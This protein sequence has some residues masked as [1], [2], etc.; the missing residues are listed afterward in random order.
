[1]RQN[2]AEL[3]AVA[4]LAAELGLR[5]ISIFPVIRRDEIPVRFPELER[6]SVHTPE[7]RDELNRLVESV[8][9][10]QPEIA[11]AICNPQFTDPDVCLGETPTPC[12]GDLAAGAAIY[13][14]EQNPWE[15]AHIL[16]NG[17]V[18][19]CEVH[20]RLTLGSLA[21][22]SLAEIWHGEPYRRF[23]ERYRAGGQA[24]CRGCPWKTAYMP[25]PLRGE[26]LAARGRSAQLVHGWHEPD[27]E[28][29]LWASQQA[30]AVVHPAADA[31]ALHVH[32]IL[33]PGPAGTA[34]RLSIRCNGATIGE[35]RNEGT[36][37]LTFGEDLP[38]CDASAPWEIEF[39]TDHVYAASGD[40]RDL[41]FA[42][43]AATA[44][45]RIDKSRLRRQ[46]AALR[47]LMG[48]IATI[49]RLGR[50]M[51]ERFSRGRAE[52]SLLLP[53]APGLSVIV[54]ERDNPTELAQC[55]NGL[56]AATR[57]WQ[58]TLEAIIVVNG[59]DP[60]RY[61]HLRAAHPWIQW[62]FHPRPLG[63]CGAVAA[64]VRRA[65]YDWVY[66]LNSDAVLEPTA[67]AEV[68]R[69][70]APLTFSVASQIYL[71]DQTRYR[72][73]TNWTRILVEDG[74]VNIH[75]LIPRS[76][77]VVEHFYAGGGASL[78]QTRLLRR[79]LRPRLY[80][81]FYWEDVEWGW[82]ARKLGYRSLFCAGS[83]AHHTQRAT[84]SRYYP[85]EQVE[86]V[87]HRNRLLFQLRNLTATGSM[88]AA[89][90]AI[91]SGPR[92]T[93]EYFVHPR[94]LGAVVRGR[95]WNHLAPVPDSE[96]LGC[97]Q[98]IEEPS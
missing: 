74:L 97:S 75:D 47:P 10:E 83:V 26:I 29:L 72:E 8:R 3:P 61:E 2:L 30:M 49:D 37:L 9:R 94:T 64:G 11:L 16:A 42:L 20:D 65:A 31:G 54:P 13:S 12:P 22:Q 71:K 1:M 93:A 95:L 88:D 56:E 36:D 92:E 91:A 60:S 76:Q 81:P 4:A 34:N 39:R 41:G 45:P 70:R 79:L 5:S 35:L 50:A 24:E 51:A 18:V 15:T 6:G 52:E 7:F 44:K 17:D 55:L 80:H 40:Q 85:T 59:G 86:S 67:L 66:L 57:L 53:L 38:I 82:R 69:W 78:F 23:R 62:Q 89:M 90:A 27:G 14:C 19:P 25:T 58:E 98:C 33:P 21:R 32:G 46:R 48:A 63:F 87:L 73:E 28:P 68:G 77:R 84:I 43:V 96:V